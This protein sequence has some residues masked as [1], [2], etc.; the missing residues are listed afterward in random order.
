MSDISNAARKL[1]GAKDVSLGAMII[2][3][4]WIGILS[5]I[6][7]F[8]PLATDKSFGLEMNEIVLS[9]IVLAAVFSPVYFS[10]FLDKIRDIRLGGK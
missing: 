2:A 7:A 10:I 1:P 3:G 5:L 9:G 4:L 8:W 6:K